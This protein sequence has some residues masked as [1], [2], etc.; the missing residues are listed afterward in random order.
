[1][2]PE[3]MEDYERR[4]YSGDLGKDDDDEGEEWKHEEPKKF[5]APWHPSDFGDE[6]YIGCELKE[7]T[8]KH[9]IEGVSKITDWNS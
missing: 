7:L 1:M 2:F 8:P 5:E 9:L 6:F 4:F 3:D